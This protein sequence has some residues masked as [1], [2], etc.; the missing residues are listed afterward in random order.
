MADL[1]ILRRPA[2]IEKTGLSRCTI[3]NMRKENKF[4]QPIQL[5]PRNI[6]WIESEVDEWIMQKI[7]ERDKSEESG[8]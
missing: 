1:R 5:G 3:E 6:G 8:H 4:P 7:E 2:V